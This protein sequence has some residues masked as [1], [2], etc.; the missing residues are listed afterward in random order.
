MS[1]FM[2]GIITGTFTTLAAIGSYRILFEND[3]Q[4]SNEFKKQR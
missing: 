2:K 3:N 1:Q 4:E